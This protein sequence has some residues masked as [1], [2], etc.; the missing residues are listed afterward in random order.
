MEK[1]HKR[2]SRR[3][4]YQIG[5]WSALIAAIVFRRWLGSELSLFQSMGL[6][7]TGPVPA[8]QDVQGWFIFLQAHPLAGLTLLN[9]FDL[10]NYM[11]VGL[12]FLGL[13]AALRKAHRGLMTL[14]LALTVI[15]ISV[16]LA[17]NQAF[18]ILALGRQYVATSN[19]AQQAA[20]LAAGQLALT[21][22]DFLSGASAIPLAFLCVDLAGLIIAW[23]MLNSQVF[24][25]SAA[26]VGLVANGIGLLVFPF[27]FFAPGLVFIPFSASAPFLLVWYV[28][29]GWRLLKL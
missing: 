20:L 14:A 27:L 18:T 11:L 19:P 9:V 29:I 12:I 7:Q 5:G 17:S 25:R 13:Y 10:V 23:V 26:I 15:G 2:D 24:S 21:T 1:Q 4:L 28:Q 6:F 8:A 22:N 16:Y 3:I